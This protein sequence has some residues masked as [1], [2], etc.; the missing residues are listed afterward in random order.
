M[1][2]EADNKRKTKTR[3]WRMGFNRCSS[4]RGDPHV[5]VGCSQCQA[6]AVNGVPIHEAG[7]PNDPRRRN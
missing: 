2:E 5:R 1:S 4:V 3:L 6:T 7:C